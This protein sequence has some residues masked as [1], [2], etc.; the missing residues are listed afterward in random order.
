MHAPP[1]PTSKLA[2][3]LARCVALGSSALCGIAVGLGTYPDVTASAGVLN[4]I[5]PFAYAPVLT[6]G[7]A[8][9]WHH[10]LG[11]AAHA[12]E[13]HKQAVAAGI[14]VALFAFGCATSA[15][16]LAAKFGG[17]PALQEY[18][19][20]YV[21]KLGEAADGVG[22]NAASEQELIAALEA[23]GNAL[24]ATAD[25]EGSSGIRSGK[26][27][28][29]VVFHTL[30]DAAASL[31]A[32]ASALT[33]KAAERERELSRAQSD[34]AESRRASAARNDAQFGEAINRA[35]SLISAANKMNL[36]ASVSALGIGVT[37]DHAR[38]AV[39]QAFG[40]IAEVARMVNE[41][42]RAVSVPVYAPVDAKKAVT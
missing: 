19:L 22:V 20:G 9:A 24:D 33:Q 7:L 25:S 8:A 23:G 39:D 32:M 4:F 42:R 18:Q 21:E 11:I 34:I 38:A 30:K 17:A 35:A 40:E 13:L 15:W 16:F 3:G 28:K 29:G 41:R 1:R 2:L 5:L 12:T 31:S 27:G 26:T 36:T 37:K 10:V 14:G 6:V